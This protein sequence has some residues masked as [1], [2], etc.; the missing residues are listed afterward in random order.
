MIDPSERF[1]LVLDLDYSTFTALMLSARFGA[2]RARGKYAGNAVAIALLSQATAGAVNRIGTERWNALIET[3]RAQAVAKS[4]K[5]AD[6]MAA[7]RKFMD[8]TP[9]GSAPRHRAK[10]P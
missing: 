1:Q 2:D 5:Y 9:L 10:R 7:A 8:E 6:D 4:P 3:M